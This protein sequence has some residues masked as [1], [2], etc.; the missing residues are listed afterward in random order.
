MPVF[1]NGALTASPRCK[2]LIGGISAQKIPHGPVYPTGSAGYITLAFRKELILNRAKSVEALLARA[3]QDFSALKKAYDASLHEKHV[4][5]DLK[6][7]IKNIYENL[8]SCL[9]YI[10]HDTFE[11]FCS[12]SKKP[13]RLYFPIRPSATEFKQAI[14]KDFPALNTSA[15][16]LYACLE[17]VQPYNSDWLGKFNKLNNHNKHQDLTEQTRTE[18]RQVTVSR[19]GGSVSWG[20]G[21]SFGS[22]VSVV[23]VPIDPRTQMPV[24]NVVAKTEVVIWVDF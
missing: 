1:L 6:V 7:S 2:P 15:P 17:A 3:K 16:G 24:P 5:E 18:A 23:G 4:R 20:P 9:D 10:A 11:K 19:A 14:S 12:A 13:D 8:R 22:G 21:V